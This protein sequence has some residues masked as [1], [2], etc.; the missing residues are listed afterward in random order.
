MND[1]KTGACRR[2]F[3]AMYPCC[4]LA[5]FWSL[6]VIGQIELPDAPPVAEPKVPQQKAS[7]ADRREIEEL[8]QQMKGSNQ[9]RTSLEKR[10]PEKDDE[11]ALIES[12]YLDRKKIYVVKVSLTSGL[13]VWG[14]VE[15]QSLRVEN[16][17]G[18]F[19]LVFKEIK[20][21][22]RQDE[23]EG[24]F[25]FRLRDD[26]KIWGKPSLTT[27]KLRLPH[28]GGREILLGEIQTIVFPDAE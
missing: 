1:N 23:E 15:N 7:E 11:V 4:I 21:A 20:S 3:C 19:P 28:G 22:N 25:E 14:E 16:Q 10:R 2:F 27:I 17:V 6:P 24:F 18:E 5:V 8:I 26:D 12:L 13:E 9:R